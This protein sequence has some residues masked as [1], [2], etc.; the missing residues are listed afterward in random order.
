MRHLD[1]PLRMSQHLHTA[2]L[3]MIFSW[4]RAGR[5][6]LARMLN[7]AHGMRVSKCCYRSVM[8]TY[9]SRAFMLRLEAK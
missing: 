2:R 6:I 4:V 8:M 3:A 1:S 9:L 5:I 7:H